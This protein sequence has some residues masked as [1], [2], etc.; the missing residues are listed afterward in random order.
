MA[1]LTFIVHYL[2]ISGGE[3]GVFDIEDLV[4]LLRCDNADDICVISIASELEF[5]DHMV[6]VTGRSIRH[7]TAI[8]FYV[9]KLV[10]EMEMSMV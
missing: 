3:N 10:G 6:I 7:I 1:Y 2:Y 5:V 4:E 9:K 8:A